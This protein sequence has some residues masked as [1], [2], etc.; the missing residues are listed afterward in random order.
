MEVNSAGTIV[1]SL[2]LPLHKGRPGIS[3]Q[4]FV[5]RGGHLTEL[6]S[7]PGYPSG[8]ASAINDRGDI[9][10]NAERFEHEGEQVR[11]LSRAYLW[12]GGRRTDLGVLPGC[13]SAMVNGINNLGEII[14][15]AASET[16]AVAVGL[17]RPFVWQNH[18]LTELKLPEGRKSSS[19]FGLNDHG[20]IVGVAGNEDG[21]G[22]NEEAVAVLWRGGQVYDLNSLIPSD[23]GWTL[24]AAHAVNNQGQIAGEG[25]HDGQKRAF[26]LTPLQSPQ[27]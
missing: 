4:A 24:D 22:L 14:G 10:C 3:S 25:L 12:S 6:P 23:A 27:P 9:A 21:T 2:L 13:N 5:W 18:H 26:L 15:Q 11:L 7:M 8:A 17:Q 20:E 16:Y 1:G 19:P